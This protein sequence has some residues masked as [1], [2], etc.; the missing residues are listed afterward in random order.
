[1]KLDIAFFEP[2]DYTEFDDDKFKSCA[3]VHLP[4]SEDEEVYEN[5]I[6]YNIGERIAQLI[7]IPYPKIE[8]KEVE[9]LTK[10][11]RGDGGYGSSGK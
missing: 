3:D 5:A 8:F 4:Q 7:I 1:M 2:N 9:E 6:K 10:T 11:E